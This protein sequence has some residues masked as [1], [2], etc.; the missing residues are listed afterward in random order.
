ME[1]KALIVLTLI[2]INV[3]L[4]HRISCDTCVRD[5]QD[6]ANATE[7]LRD[8]SNFE[9]LGDLDFTMDPIV[10]ESFLDQ[11]RFEPVPRLT[12]P[13]LCKVAC[14]VLPPCMAYAFVDDVVRA[15]GIYNIIPNRY[16]FY[17]TLIGPGDE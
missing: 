8:P 9:L 3:T 16:V 13:R 11:C 7:L 14:S 4:F 10:L 6:F 1:I 17:D 5:I 15:S 2:T 12:T